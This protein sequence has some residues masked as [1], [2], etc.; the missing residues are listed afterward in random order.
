MCQSR[1]SRKINIQGGKIVRVDKCLEHL[2]EHVNGPYLHTLGCCCGHE[3]YPMTIVA[4]DEITEKIMEICSNKEI[5]RKRRFYV[6]DKNG[7]YFIPEVIKN[8]KR[9]I[10]NRTKDR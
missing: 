2:I 6:K 10:S 7:Y 3:K 8:E 1:S 9:H 5:P 4:Y